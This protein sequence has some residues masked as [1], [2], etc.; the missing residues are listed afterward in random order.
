MKLLYIVNQI[1]GTTGLERILSIKINHFI[2]EYGYEVGLMAI[3]EV[4]SNRFFQFSPK[5]KYS[6]INSGGTVKPLSFLNKISKV[7]KQIKENRP[8]VIIVCIDN[9]IGLYLPFFLGTDIP[10]VYERHNSL[11]ANFASNQGFKR[12]GVFKILKTWLLRNGG[13]KY[14]RFVLLSKDHLSEWKHLSNTTVISNPAVFQSESKAVLENK[15]VLAVGRHSYQKG[16]DFLLKSW[17]KVVKSHPDWRL[18]IFGKK[19]TK[20]DLEGLAVSYGIEKSV[21]FC[22]PVKNI[23]EEY[24]KSSIFAL[25]SRYEGFPLVLIESMSFGLPPVAFACPY[26]V[27]EIVTNGEDG[28]TVKPEDVEDLSKGIITLIENDDLR[29]KMGKNAWQNIKRLSKDRIMEQWHQLFEELKHSSI[30]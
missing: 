18:N 11:N 26:G 30:P 21:H 7:K 19:D 1:N 2:E 13:A 15:T 16:F 10:M 23:G 4:S 12:I 14:S 5:M 25:S 20:M 22:D 17:Q 9:V 29:K 6:F 27:Q 24:M 28:I 3:N 8:D